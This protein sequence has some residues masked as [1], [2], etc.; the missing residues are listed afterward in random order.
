[1][2]CN[3]GC[4]CIG[5]CV[6][7][8]L[9][10]TL[11]GCCTA[12]TSFFSINTHAHIQRYNTKESCSQRYTKRALPTTT[13]VTAPPGD[14]VIMRSGALVLKHQPLGC[15][16]VLVWRLNACALVLVHSPMPF[17]CICVGRAQRLTAAGECLYTSLCF[18][19]CFRSE[20]WPPVTAQT[21]R[22]KSKR[23]MRHTYTLARAF[24]RLHNG[25]DVQMYECAQVSIRRI[26]KQMR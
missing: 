8:R 6:A 19:S 13:D 23:R 18:Y 26:Q 15:K 25:T 4:V 3:I 22:E 5:C 1:M 14:Y 21:E 9:G 20:R 12:H 24:K 10:S 17:T 16:G 11:C 2:S 7:F